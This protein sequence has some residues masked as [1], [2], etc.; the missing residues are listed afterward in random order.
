MGSRP[1]FL[2]RYRGDQDTVGGRGKVALS[3]DG[4]DAKPVGG[5]LWQI[6]ALI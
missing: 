3:P 2:H 6:R 5:E 4:W 1:K